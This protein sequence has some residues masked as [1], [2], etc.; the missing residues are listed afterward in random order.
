MVRRLPPLTSRS[1]WRGRTGAILAL[2]LVGLAAPRP[3]DRD[4]G[5]Y[6]ILGQKRARL[7]N[8][9]IEPP[10]CSVGVNCPLPARGYRC[11]GLSATGPL[12]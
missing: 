8:L 2:A 1:W 7:K 11:G 9:A 5:D 6:V 3:V 10:G 12:L 4:P